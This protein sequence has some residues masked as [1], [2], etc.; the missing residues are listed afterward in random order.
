MPRVF[1]IPLL[2]KQYLH[3]EVLNKQK[4]V[5]SQDHLL[6]NVVPWMLGLGQTLPWEFALPW[7]IQNA[8][9]SIHIPTERPQENTTET[10][11]HA[12]RHNEHPLAKPCPARV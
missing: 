5:I 3:N 2:R 10:S 11:E 6:Q 8:A 4:M 1:S 7:Q 9:F 12:D